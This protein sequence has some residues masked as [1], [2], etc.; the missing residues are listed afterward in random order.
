MALK[1]YGMSCIVNLHSNSQFSPVYSGNRSEL[2][3]VLVH[4]CLLSCKTVLDRPERCWT[5]LCINSGNFNAEFMEFHC[6]N[7][8]CI[9]VFL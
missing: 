5:T 6:M 8:L 1:I 9:P 3:T 2:I 7:T 4:K